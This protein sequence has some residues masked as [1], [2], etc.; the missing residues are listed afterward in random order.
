[1]IT[2]LSSLIQKVSNWKIFCVLLVVYA[3]YFSVFFYADVPFG[4]SKIKPY[5]GDTSILDVEMYYT[6]EQA[7]QRL[8]ILGEQGR[9]AYMRILMGDLVYPALLGSFLSVAITQVFRHAFP[10]NSVWHKLNLLPLANMTVDYL[11]NILLITL[12]T[13]YPTHLNGVA[14]IAGFVTLVKN[15]FGLLS[16][17]ALGAGLVALLYRG[18]SHWRSKRERPSTLK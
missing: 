2:R 16:F 10:A 5:A 13:N 1:M 9:A 17:L 7:Y 3:L 14:T 11:E 15:L 12:L 4:L 8:A 6:P 18:V